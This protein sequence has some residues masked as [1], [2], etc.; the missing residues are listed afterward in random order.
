MRN[1]SWWD[2]YY[3]EERATKLGFSFETG[4]LDSIRNGSWNIF[5][6]FPSSIYIDSTYIR[7]MIE[8]DSSML[9][10]NQCCAI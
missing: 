8:I 3:E 5:T 6:D 4:R 9:F 7:H 10:R 2:I 1:R